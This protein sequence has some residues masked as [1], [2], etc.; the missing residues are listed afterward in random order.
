MVALRTFLYDPLTLILAATVLGGLGQAFIK[1]GVSKVGTIGGF[2][3]K[4][5]QALLTPEVIAGFTAYGLSALLYLM[6][7]SKKGLS[8]AYPFVALNQVIVFFLAWWLFKEPIPPVRLFGI[9][10]ICVGVV[11]VALS[12]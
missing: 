10:V 4:L 11:L 9:S 7:V 6:V 3:L 1:R 2:N 8:F 5:I 12:K